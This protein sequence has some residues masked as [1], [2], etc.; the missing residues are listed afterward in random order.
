M[1]SSADPVLPPRRRQSTRVFHRRVRAPADAP[2]PD[3]YTQTEQPTLS[4]R[5][6]RGW[7]VKND[8]TAA[9]GR[10]QQI[11]NLSYPHRTDNK[12]CYSR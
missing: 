2:R 9:L 11:D 5:P 6:I 3:C 10:A 4:V 7:Q 8:K 1:A 12:R